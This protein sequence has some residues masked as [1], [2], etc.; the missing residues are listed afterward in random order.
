MGPAAGYLGEQHCRKENRKCKA[1]V[2]YFGETAKVMW[3]K[4]KSRADGDETQEWEGNC[5]ALHL[6]FNIVERIQKKKNHTADFKLYKS[7]IMGLHPP[8]LPYL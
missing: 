2:C 6:K 3:R 7:G 4:L 5:L 1:E 8:D